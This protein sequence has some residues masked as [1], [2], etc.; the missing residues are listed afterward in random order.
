LS[1]ALAGAPSSLALLAGALLADL[2]LGEPPASFHPVVWMGRMTIL[3]ERR[4]GGPSAVHPRPP[5]AQRAAGLLLALAL[6]VLFAAGAAAAIRGGGPLPVIGWAIGVWLTKSTFAL[7][8]LGR[9]AGQVRAPLASGDLAGARRALAAL[10]SRDPAVLDEAGL[11]AGTVSS[12]AENGCD[13]FVAPLFYFALGGL[14]A[15][16]FYRAVNTLDAMI[17]YRGRYEH[18]GK[19]AARLDDA[20]NFV[21]A[22]LAALLLLAA[23]ALLGLDVRRG[24]RTLRRDGALT[25]SPNGG[26]PMAAMAGLLGVE[27]EKPGHYRLGAGG[28]APTPATIDRA[29]RVV[30][31]AGALAAALALV[32][33][34][35]T[36]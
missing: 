34:G 23:G 7:R 25:A 4:L 11:A 18:F 28:A 19:A 29:W 16:M 5:G 22:R 9:A 35:G 31:L 33:V 2:T 27:L 15:A 32:V 6:P 30:V 13:S 17:G 1:A 26:R 24:W 36:R 8:A 3:A 10:C 12:L 21:P 20:L 14:P